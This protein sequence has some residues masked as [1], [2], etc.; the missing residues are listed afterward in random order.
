MMVL[1]SAKDFHDP[2]A[3]ILP[4]TSF[5]NALNAC[6]PEALLSREGSP[7]VFQPAML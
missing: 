5:A 4:Q 7:E 1:A 3:N 6:H 2:P